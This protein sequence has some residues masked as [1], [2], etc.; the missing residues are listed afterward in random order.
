M[1]LYVRIEHC[2]EGICVFAFGLSLFSYFYV[3]VCVF[4]DLCKV[5]KFYREVAKFSVRL[6]KFGV[7][8]A[9]ILGENSVF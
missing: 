4:F 5:L 9:I 3:N 7:R 2:S 6:L 8:F 1:E